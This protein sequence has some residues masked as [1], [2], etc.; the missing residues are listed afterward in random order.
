MSD[1]VLFLLG[2]LGFAV[3]L[4]LDSWWE[5]QKDLDRIERWRDKRND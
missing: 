5:N 1:D 4:Y 2:V 3:M